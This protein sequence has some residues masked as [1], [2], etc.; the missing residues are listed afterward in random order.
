MLNKGM[1]LEEFK[2]IIRR[3]VNEKVEEQIY[4]KDRTKE[5][6]QKVLEAI[7]IS[8]DIVAMLDIIKRPDVSL[9]RA[10]DDLKTLLDKAI[11]SI[12]WGA[13]LGDALKNESGLKG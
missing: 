9:K 7:T 13:N 11:N 3:Y 8:F 5:V 1:D 6:T 2:S 12:V 10:E 4:N